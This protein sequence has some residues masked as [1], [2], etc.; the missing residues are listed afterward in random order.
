MA[1]I[2]PTEDQVFAVL[3]TFLA[4]IL[5]I[6]ASDIVRAQDNRVPEPTAPNFIVMTPL[7]T[8]RIATNVVENLD[9]LYQGSITNNVLTVTSVSYGTISVGNPV[10]GV[11]VED[12]TE[13]STLG[14]GEGGPGT[15]IINTPQDISETMLASGVSSYTEESEWVVQID[16]HGPNS[17]DNVKIISVLWRDEYTVDQFNEIAGALTPPIAQ[18]VIEPL[19]GD[20]PKQAPFTDAEQQ[21]ELRW[22]L[23]VHFQVNQT[24]IVGQQFADAV[25]IGLINVDAAYPP[26]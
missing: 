12:G 20:D 24:V 13:I 18:G 14:T 16:V 10:Y 11:D 7:F 21:Y 8:P 22:L 5:T 15:Y 23:D 17:N 6:G 25:T 3:Q 2:S 4:S 9:C 1:S 26:S 19:N